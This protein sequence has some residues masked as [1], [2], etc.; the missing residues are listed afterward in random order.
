LSLPLEDNRNIYNLDIDF[1]DSKLKEKSP[2]KGNLEGE[3]GSNLYPLK[4]RDV[5]LKTRWFE[6]HVQMT[7]SD[8]VLLLLRC[9]TIIISVL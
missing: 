3:E 6:T 4:K 8:C 1:D 9:I 7:Q 5:T 2:K